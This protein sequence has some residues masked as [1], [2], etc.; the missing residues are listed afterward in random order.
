[1][2]SEKKKC[3]VKDILN[4]KTKSESKCL[5]AVKKYFPWLGEIVRKC[6]A[7]SVIK[8][9]TQWLIKFKTILEL[10]AR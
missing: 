4:D 6:L 5:G 10:A 2:S 7:L 3:S 9:K 8:D 1:M